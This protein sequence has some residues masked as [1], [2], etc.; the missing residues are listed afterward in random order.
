M[1]WGRQKAQ[2]NRA[3][4]SEE[5]CTSIRSAPKPKRTIA[6]EVGVNP[7][8]LDNWLDG[9]NRAGVGDKRIHRIAELLGFPVE[10]IFA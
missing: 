6:L 9:V 10:R 7:G 2:K 5:F 3:F 4:L 1:A 8:V